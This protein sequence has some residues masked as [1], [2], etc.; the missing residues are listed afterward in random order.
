MLSQPLSVITLNGKDLNSPIKD[1]YLLTNSESTIQQFV[2]FKNLIQP[3]KDIH[4]LKKSKNSETTF[5][6]P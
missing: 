1:K 4:T 6:A 2:T 5:H 3:K